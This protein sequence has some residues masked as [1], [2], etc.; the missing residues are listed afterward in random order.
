MTA[1]TAVPLLEL[2][3]GLSYECRY[4]CGRLSWGVPVHVQLK[5]VDGAQFM[6]EVPLGGSREAISM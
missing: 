3:L 2:N 5:I 4:R 1:G 6:G